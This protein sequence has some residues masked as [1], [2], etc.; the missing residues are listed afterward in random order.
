MR[1]LL[2][3][4]PLVATVSASIVSNRSCLVTNYL[5]ISAAVSNC[6][7]I[8]LRDVYMPSNTTLDLTKLKSGSV[9]TFEGRTTF[10]F[11]NSS[12]FSPIILGGNHVTITAAPDSVIE[13]NGTLYWD[14]LG[15]NGGVPKYVLLILT[16]KCYVLIRNRPNTFITIKKMTNSSLI[17]NLTIKNWPV[18]LFSIQSSSDLILQNLF[19]DNRDGE[20]PNNRSNGLAAAHNSDGFG[21]KESS[22]VAIKDSRVY[23]QDDCVAV[24]SGDR[25]VVTGLWCEGG[26]GLSIGSVGGKGNNNVTNILVSRLYS[27]LCHTSGRLTV[28]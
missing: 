7:N 19:L 18:H 8:A 21:V 15:S 6:T 12:S 2:A 26:H 16:Q 17:S 5:K 20:A 4:V 10:G 25:V 1:L 9:V 27:I 14:G 28:K 24:T 3:I 23:N 13:G 11:T 22:N